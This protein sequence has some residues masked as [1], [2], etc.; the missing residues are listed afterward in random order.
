[1]GRGKEPAGHSPGPDARGWQIPRLRQA[2]RRAAKPV[3][4]GRGRISDLGGEPPAKQD[5][6]AQ[7][8]PAGHER[9]LSDRTGTERALCCAN[10]SV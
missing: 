5:R 3:P 1:M 10:R 7:I 8:H 6:H 2:D 4:E 9:I